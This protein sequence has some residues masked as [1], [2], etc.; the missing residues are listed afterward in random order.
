MKKLSLLS[1]CVSALFVLA[2]CNSS[3]GSD[4]FNDT[5]LSTEKEL[6]AKRG[7]LTGEGGFDLLGGGDK[8][9]P[10]AALG[11][12]SYIWRATL[13]TLS[14]MPITSADPFGGTILTD[15]Y[16]DPKT[17]GERFKINALITDTA[18]RADAIKVTLF[19]Q[20]KDDKGNWRDTEVSPSVPRQLENTILTRARELRVNKEAEK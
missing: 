17:P 3:G 11:V 2:A 4:G 15:W 12:N 6:Q 20:T 19:K 13:D 8:A 10:G 1:L 14:F 16:E 7:K 18:M 5:P 9:A